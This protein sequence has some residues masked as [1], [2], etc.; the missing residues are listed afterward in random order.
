MLPPWWI[1]AGVEPE[2]PD[3]DMGG[4]TAISF[5]QAQQDQFAVDIEGKVLP[6]RH[7]HHIAGLQLA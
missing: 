3:R 1:L 2:G 6:N 4:W 7:V 5:T